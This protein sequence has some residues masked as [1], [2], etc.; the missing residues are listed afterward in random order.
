[1]IFN[2]FMTEVSIYK[3]QSTDFQSKSMN[4]FQHDRD[5]R[6]ERVKCNAACRSFTIMTEA[7][8]QR[9]SLKNLFL[10]IS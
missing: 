7:A 10:I 5:L 2:S 8:A 9:C 3:S 6:H 4:W 1:M